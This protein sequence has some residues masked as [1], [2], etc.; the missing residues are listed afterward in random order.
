MKQLS[1]F[2]LVF[3][4]HILLLYWLYNPEFLNLLWFSTF[5][6]PFLLCFLNDWKLRY[7]KNTSKIYNFEP[8]L[9]FTSVSVTADFATAQPI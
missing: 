2:F 7:H 1:D 6:T 3:S 9:N 8:L 4:T 5:P